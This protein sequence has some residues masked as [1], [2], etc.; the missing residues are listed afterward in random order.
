MIISGNPLE[1]TIPS[2][3]G[4]LEELI[5]LGMSYD[6]LSGTIPSSLGQLNN[7]VNFELNNN[8]LTGSV[9]LEIANKTANKTYDNFNVYGNKLSNLTD[10]DGLTI[11]TLI[12]N[13]TNEDVEHY[14]NCGSDCLNENGNRCE[15]E[16]AQV[17]CDNYIEQNNITNCVVCEAGFSNPELIVPEWDYAS[18]NDTVDYVYDLL[19]EFGTEEQ[20]NGVKLEINRRGC[21]CPGFVVV[22]SKE[23]E[24]DLQV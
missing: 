24:D 21:I 12:S 9:S 19:A 14:C 10:V 18:C 20:C 1:G 6:E 3:L 15:C 5:H 22:P 13:N 17:C 7:L 4:Q 8:A 11:C 23:E 16:E 2:E